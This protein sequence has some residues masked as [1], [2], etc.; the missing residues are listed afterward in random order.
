MDCVI[1]VY[2]RILAFDHTAES[3]WAVMARSVAVL[4]L[5]N[6]TRSYWTRHFCV[7]G[8]QK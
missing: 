1:C 6:E 2:N 8:V 7:Q 4:L 5:A 3:V